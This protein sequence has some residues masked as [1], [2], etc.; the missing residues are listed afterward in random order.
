MSDSA[1]SG[2][3]G[4]PARILERLLRRSGAF[5]RYSEA[6]EIDRGGQ[7]AILRVWDG[8]LERPLAMK[9]LRGGSADDDWFLGFNISRKFF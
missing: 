8:D 6:S 3:P 1:E 9:V 2:S 5:E 4:I 7:G